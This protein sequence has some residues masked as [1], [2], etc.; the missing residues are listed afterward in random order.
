MTSQWQRAD[1]RRTALMTVLFALVVFAII[2]L[3]FY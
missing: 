2:L 1:I 3:L